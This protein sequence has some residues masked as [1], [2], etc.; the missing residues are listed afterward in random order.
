V[1]LLDGNANM[2]H[3]VPF[4]EVDRAGREDILHTVQGQ[5]PFLAHGYRFVRAIFYADLHGP[6]GSQSLGFGGPNLGYLHDPELSFRRPMSE[7]LTQ[8]GYMP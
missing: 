2:R 5:L 4:A 3:G 6:T 1:L 7:E 8:H